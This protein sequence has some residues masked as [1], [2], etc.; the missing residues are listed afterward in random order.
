[1]IVTA[2]EV[3]GFGTGPAG[4]KAFTAS[5]SLLG[6][7]GSTYV[8]NWVGDVITLGTTISAFGCCLA[9]VVG[10]ARLLY[11]LSRDTAGPRGLG[12]SSS[13]WGTPVWATL[14]IVAMAGLIVIIET[15]VAAQPAAFNSFLWSG[16]IGTLILLV[17]YVLASVGCIMLVFVRHK[18]PVPMWQIVVPIAGLIVLGYTLYRNVIP[19]PTGTPRGSPWCPALAG[20]GGD[21][22]D[23]RAGHGPQARRGAGRPRGHRGTGHRGGGRAPA[24]V[25]AGRRV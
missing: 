1:M 3:M 13:R 14:A 24:R 8:G 6:D 22:G 12:Q 18:L 21:G 25:G 4:I 20:G 23:L 15:A 11:A 19:Y 7:L 17:V 10:A 2:V 9:C 16:T 5:P